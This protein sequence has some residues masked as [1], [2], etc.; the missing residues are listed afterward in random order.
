MIGEGSE[1]VSLFQVEQ[2]LTEA[3]HEIHNL[4][5][6]NEIMHGKLEVLDLVAALLNAPANYGARP[7]SPDLVFSIER[8]RDGIKAQR[9]AETVAAAEKAAAASA[10][11][12][13]SPPPFPKARKP[14]NDF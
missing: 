3:A 8:M 4:R 11:V 5:R 12:E 1:A 6:Q 10:E 9:E 13:I 2:T 7:M 14:S